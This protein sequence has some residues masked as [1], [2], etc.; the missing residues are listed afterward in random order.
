MTSQV[1]VVPVNVGNLATRGYFCRKSK[2]KTLGNQRKV[3]WA[4]ERFGEGLE[5]EIV[6]DDG[7]SV[8]FVEHLPG[9]HAWRAV[10]ADGYTLIHCIWVVGRA[11]GKGYGSQLLGRVEA[12]AQAQG[13]NGVA[14]V[15]SSGNWLADEMLLT[16]H[17]YTV[18]DEAPPS[19]RLMVKSFGDG[20]VP[21]FPTNWR[22]VLPL[23]ATV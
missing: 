4:T 9:E 3:D 16:K 19:F 22:S 1:E 6:Y 7:R 20:P 5:I 23:S 13:R 12:S 14:M 21:R 8:G 17:G 11:K 18:V 2:M 10:V 15:V